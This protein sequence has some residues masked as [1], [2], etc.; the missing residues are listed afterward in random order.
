MVWC[1]VVWCFFSARHPSQRAGRCQR[2]QGK[3]DA[4]DSPL[5]DCRSAAGGGACNLRS[6][7]RASCTRLRFCGAGGG[8]RSCHPRPERRGSGTGLQAAEPLLPFPTPG[9]DVTSTRAGLSP[10]VSLRMSPRPPACFL[11]FGGVAF[12]ATAQLLSFRE[13]PTEGRRLRNMGQ[14]RRRGTVVGHLRFAMAIS[15]RPM[16]CQV[17][18]SP[19]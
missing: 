7:S 4:Y 1:G 5:S 19:L 12:A 17:A 13:E 6:A 11:L 9:T 10:P 14:L 2:T 3:R 15:Q 16:W 18:L 8:Q